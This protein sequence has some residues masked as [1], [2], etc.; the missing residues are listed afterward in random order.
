MTQDAD[1]NIQLDEV[2]AAIEYCSAGGDI[3][4]RRITMRRIEP[5]APLSAPLRATPAL[6]CP[7]ARKS[8]IG[9]WGYCRLRMEAARQVYSSTRHRP[10]PSALEYR[11]RTGRPPAFMGLSEAQIR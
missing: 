4:R 10:K 7:A 9:L 11:H 5:T 1:G 3:S 6:G 2:F 8:E